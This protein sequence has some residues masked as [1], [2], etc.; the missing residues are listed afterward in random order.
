[1]GACRLAEAVR[2]GHGQATR[3]TPPQVPHPLLQ[4]KG[5]HQPRAA[6]KTGH[7]SR[8]RGHASQPIE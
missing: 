4:A 1:M 7:A 8:E 3:E 6:V 5:L 2:A